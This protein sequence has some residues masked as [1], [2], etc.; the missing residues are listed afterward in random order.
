M[1]HWISSE[2]GKFDLVITDIGMPG[3][4]GIDLL[5][6]IKKE[7]PEMPVIIMTGMPSIEAAVECMKIGADDYLSKPFTAASLI[8]VVHSVI[9]EARSAAN[10]ELGETNLV[11]GYV[12]SMIGGYEIVSKLGEGNRGVVLLGEKWIDDEKSQY[13]IK[14]MKVNYL[15]EDKLNETLERFERE[16]RVAAKVD[17][18]NTV[19]IFDYAVTRKKK[20]PFIVMEYIEGKS[21]TPYIGDKSMEIRQKV[22]I[23]RQVADALTALHEHG[24]AHRDVKPGNIML[25]KDGNIKLT[26]FG[27]VRIPDSDLT[28]LYDII[29]TPAYLSPESFMTARVDPRSDLFSLGVVAYEL[30]L[31]VRPFEGAN[32]PTIS[33]SIT[34]TLPV[35]P[36]KLDRN[37]SVRLQ[38]ILA[39]MLKKDPDERYQTANEIVHAFEQFL[40]LYPDRVDDGLARD[41]DLTKRDWS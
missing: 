21:L 2:N 20:I 39:K 11:Q 1:R 4:S 23:L 3:P 17:H 14:M 30:L 15:P 16:A 6:E 35:E 9:D 25:Q 26:D 37:F 18:P 7:K 40:D 32:I 24:V 28:V 19:K 27:T 34:M 38:E 10:R 12:G 31:G 33:Q 8:E 41:P 13:A 29:G 22:D 5:A 36:A